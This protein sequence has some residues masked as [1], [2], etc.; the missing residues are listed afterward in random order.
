MSAYAQKNKKAQNSKEDFVY[1]K[2]FPSKT[3]IENSKPGLEKLYLTFLGHFSNRGQSDTATIFQYQEQEIIAVPIWKH[4]KG[5]YWIYQCRFPAGKP[6]FVVE[7]T[8]M[9]LEAGKGDSLRIQ[10][11]QL[12]TNHKSTYALEWLRAEPFKELDPKKLLPGACQSYALASSVDDFQFDCL[13]PCEYQMSNLISRVQRKGH[14]NIDNLYLFST[15]Y[16]MNDQIIFQYT[17]E[18]GLSMQRLPHDK[19]MYSE[20]L[21]SEM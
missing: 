11:Y 17:G 10:Y 6:N 19:V 15:Y 20:R 8:I 5:E 18:E 4:R 13:S 2:H 1:T 12:N 7:E 21:L 3:Q 14:I 16:D 9:K